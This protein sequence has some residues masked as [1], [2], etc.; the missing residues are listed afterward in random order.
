MTEQEAR[1]LCERRQ[2]EQPEYHWT[3][4]RRRDGDWVVARL[5]GGG[6]IN[7][8]SLAAEKGPPAEVGDDPRPAIMR[9]IPPFGPGL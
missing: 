9:N 2:A 3:A 4:Q 1:D 7:P 6:H 8:A 5:P